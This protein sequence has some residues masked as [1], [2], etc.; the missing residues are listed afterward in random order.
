M[1]FTI[2][3][4]AIVLPLK[5]FK[6]RWF[7]LTGLMAGAMSPDLLYFLMMQT[8]YRGVS[9]SWLGLLV[10]CLPA[11]IAFSFAVHHLFKQPVIHNLPWPLD[12]HLSGLAD[13]QF[14]V[15]SPRAWVVL[16]TSVLIGAL[17]HFFWDSLTHDTGEI[18]WMFPILKE[19]FTL[20]GISQP[21][22]RFI[23]HLSTFAGI[24]V[25][26]LYILKGSLVPP[27]TISRPLRTPRRK[28]LFWL[29]GSVVAAV[30][31]LLV[32]WGYDHL[33]DLRVTTGYSRHA[34]MTTV[35]LAS[36][37][38]FFYYSCITRLIDRRRE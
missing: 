29:V 1:P 12:R 32:V 36:W 6:P 28:F 5:Q 10:F 17:S 14:R 30:F 26:L 8:S 4:T 22:C 37:A 34:A 35:G 24:V 19:S 21:L 31:A 38:G 7:S 11:G 15:H 25:L 16:I 27:P 9:H 18:A 3:H 20:F 13:H 23:Q 33:Y 2:S